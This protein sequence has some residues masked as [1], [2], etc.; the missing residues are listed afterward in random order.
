[1]HPQSPCFSSPPF[2]LHH[3][4][5]SPA[6]PEEHPATQAPQHHP[7]FALTHNSSTPLHISPHIHVSI[8]NALAEL[9]KQMLILPFRGISYTQTFPSSSKLFLS[10][11]L[12]C[13]TYHTI[14]P[15]NVKTLSQKDDL[16]KV[17]NK[18]HFYYEPS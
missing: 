17:L 2:I 13:T 11:P 12:P 18:K 14:S 4:P 6:S 15:C 5:S 9:S 1:M 3:P 10:H 8:N 16:E 7:P